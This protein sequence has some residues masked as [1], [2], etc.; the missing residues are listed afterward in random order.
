MTREEIKVEIIKMVEIH[1][2][3]KATELIVYL[4]PRILKGG[5]DVV[6]IIDD[7]VKEQRLVE[8]EYV[9]PSLPYRTKSFLLPKGTS[10]S[11]VTRYK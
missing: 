1:Q 8:V 5:W 6:G 2:G 4:A 7:L 3:L 9:L 11:E 10:V